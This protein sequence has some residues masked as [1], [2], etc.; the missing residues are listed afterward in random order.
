MYLTAFENHAEELSAIQRLQWQ[1]A[2]FTESSI[3]N[4]AMSFLIIANGVTTAMELHA[5]KGDNSKAISDALEI[6]FMVS[7]RVVGSIECNVWGVA[8]DLQF[9]GLLKAA[10][11]WLDVLHRSIQRIHLL[12]RIRVL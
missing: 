3:F 2:K 5:E 7:G 6:F 9:G 11:L 10:G 1:V 8:G 12:F 4:L